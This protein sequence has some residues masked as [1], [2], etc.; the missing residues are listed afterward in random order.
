MSGNLRKEEL[1]AELAAARREFTGSWTALKSDA[2]VPRR[3]RESVRDRKA[4][5]IGGAAVLGFVLSMMRG[6]RRKVLVDA[7][8]RKKLETR[9]K[10]GLLMVLVKLALGILKPTLTAYAT[11]KLADFA[12][13][14]VEA[15]ET[16]A[17]ARRANASKSDVRRLPG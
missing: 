1:R 16:R 17:D 11:K 14:S 8:S 15:R 7:K 12:S 4:V 6:R 9:Q 10:A 13:E 2:D 5:W 3:V